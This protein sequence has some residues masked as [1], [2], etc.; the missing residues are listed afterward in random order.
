[1]KGHCF[2]LAVKNGVCHAR[3]PIDVFLQMNTRRVLAVNHGRTFCIY[4]TLLIIIIIM[5][6]IILLGSPTLAETALSFTDVLLSFLATH[7]TQMAQRTPIKCI[8]KIRS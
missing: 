6:E 7:F 1:M 2:N 5:A 8:R 3:L 4:N